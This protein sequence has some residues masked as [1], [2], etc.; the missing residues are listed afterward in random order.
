MNPKLMDIEYLDKLMSPT[1]FDLMGKYLY[2][3][4]KDKK[5]LT[6]FYVELYS[7]HIESMNGYRELPYAKS[8][9]S[10]FLSEFNKLIL[11]RML[12]LMKITKYVNIHT[13]FL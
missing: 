4:F 9:I 5:V 6:D 8:G 3:K 7:K 13:S 1:R 10:E 12:L 2:V 11:N